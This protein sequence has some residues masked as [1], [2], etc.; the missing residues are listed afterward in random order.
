[1]CI[2]IPGKVILIK[3]GKAKIKQG[4]HLHWVDISSLEDE[5]KKG[6]YLITYQGAAI[7]KIS[8]K[9]AE[10]ILRLMDSASDARVKSSN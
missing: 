6:D 2:G 9:E 8:P 7:N 4:G 5:I 1:M 3:G 10:E